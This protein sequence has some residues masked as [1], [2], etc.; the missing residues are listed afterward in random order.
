MKK[1]LFGIALTTSFTCYANI[2]VISDIDF[3]MTVDQI[4]KQVGQKSDFVKVNDGLYASAHYPLP[5][6]GIVCYSFR[7]GK[8]DWLTITYKYGVFSD[9]VKNLL[10]K[11]RFLSLQESDSNGIKK[12][13]Y[14]TDGISASYQ[15]PVDGREPFLTV[16]YQAN[17]KEIEAFSSVYAYQY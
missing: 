15:Q 7:E 17:K 1:L 2:G 13:A 4:E 3:G 6:Q 8:L 11:H 14:F 12:D 5:Q 10:R 9:M 16:R